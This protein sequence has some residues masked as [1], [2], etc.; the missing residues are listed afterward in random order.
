MTREEREYLRMMVTKKVGS[1]D[2]YRNA[3]FVKSCNINDVSTVDVLSRSRKD[4]I[5][6]SK[7]MFFAF[8]RKV[9]NETSKVIGDNYGYGHSTVLN[10]VKQHD[11]YTTYDMEYIR[12]YKKLT[13]WHKQN[14]KDYDK[15]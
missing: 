8:C 1:L 12:Q 5:I 6:K 9:L 11:N 3:A 7:T 13:D 10:L 14:L 4:K 15:N 2:I